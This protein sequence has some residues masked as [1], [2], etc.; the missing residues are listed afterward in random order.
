[1]ND[2]VVEQE[3]TPEEIAQLRLK[4]QEVERLQGQL[5]SAQQ[6]NQ[7]QT[8]DMAR[9][10]TY[11]Q[12]AIQRLSAQP[13]QQQDPEDEE[14]IKLR[15]RIQQEV[16]QTIAPS[17]L[18]S[19]QNNRAI[20]KETAKLRHG[21]DFTKYE[22]EIEEL[23][24]AYPPNVSAAPGAYDAAY[25][26]I[27]AKHLDEIIA[28]KVNKVKEELASPKKVGAIAPQRNASGRPSAQQAQEAEEEGPWNQLP[29]GDRTFLEE[30]GFSDKD[31]NQYQGNDYTEDVFGFK[32]RDRV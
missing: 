3:A 21:E 22:G 24:N 11:A 12:E 29:E 2:P 1:M 10:N 28:E 6:T 19:F 4:A 16:Q 7:Q 18:T 20:Q 25:Q 15:Q 14:T 27:R 30:L 17:Q 23:L 13:A 32:G 26:A 9:L 31:Y 8:Q 5:A